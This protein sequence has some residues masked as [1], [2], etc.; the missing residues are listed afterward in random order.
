MTIQLVPR[1]DNDPN[2]AVNV[3]TAF[4]LFEFGALDSA[5]MGMG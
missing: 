5:V 1:D 4:G 2:V 3:I